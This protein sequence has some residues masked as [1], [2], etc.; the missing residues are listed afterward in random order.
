M[1][2][3]SVV[4]D[5]APE[6]GRGLAVCVRGWCASEIGEPFPYFLRAILETQAEICN[7]YIFT[8]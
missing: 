2:W 1:P 8:R 3:R 7:M 5:E 6:T 4:G